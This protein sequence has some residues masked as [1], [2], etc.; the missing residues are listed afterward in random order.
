MANQKE[1]YYLGDD[2][3][4]QRH[5]RVERERGKKLRKSSWWKSRIQE[6]KCHF[7]QKVVGGEH[8]TMDHVVPL[9][10]GGSSTR[11]N[12][13]PACDACN[14]HKKLSTPVETLLDHLQDHTS[15]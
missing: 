13:V 10:R 9:A 12:V 8:L 1:F 2:E 15:R 3:A 5:I 6:G 14:R 4:L 11:G 7:C